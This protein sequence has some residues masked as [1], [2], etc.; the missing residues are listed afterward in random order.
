MTMYLPFP[1]EWMLGEK[2]GI[3]CGGRGRLCNVTL[4]SRF[5]VCPVTSSVGLRATLEEGTFQF[6]K[7]LC[8]EE[9]SVSIQQV[10]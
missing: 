7:E 1:I 6:S 5:C 9:G 10:Q 8:E 4:P 2:L 3:G